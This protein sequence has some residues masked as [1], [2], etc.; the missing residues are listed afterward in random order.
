MK[1]FTTSRI[2]EIDALTIRHE[3]VASVDLMERAALACTIWLEERFS[4]DT[5]FI[6]LTGPGNNGGDGWAIGRLLA[7][8]GY[9]NIRLFSVSPFS[10]LSTDAAINHQRLLDQNLVPVTVIESADQFP[11]IRKNDIILDSLF[12]S[13]LSRPLNGL[14]AEL[15][16]HINLSGAGV[17]AVDLPS[18]LMGEDNSGN[19]PD[20]IVKAKHTL[21]FQF[22]KLSFFFSENDEFVGEWT[23]LDIGLHRE[24]IEKTGTP[25]YYLTRDD[26]SRM[27]RPRRKFSHKGTYGHALLIAGSYGMMG[28]AVLASKACLRAG[29]GL[30]TV[31]IPRK[32]YDILQSAVPE[33]IVSLDPSDERFSEPPVLASYSAVGAGPGIGTTPV[34]EHALENLLQNCSKPLV[35]DADALNLIAAHKEWLERIP[36][37]SILTPHPK[38]FERLAGKSATGYD[39]LMKQIEFARDRKVILV[40]KGANTSIAMPDGTCYFN[41]TGNPGMATGGSGD[42]LTGMILSL[43][44]QGYET[45]D[46]ARTG[47]YLHGLAG[48]L[49]ACSAGRNSLI[50]S[51]ITEH[52]GSAFMKTEILSNDEKD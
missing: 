18:G 50:A 23:I 22:P 46:A 26:I 30:V 6:I 38:E 4:R 3:P 12:G 5:S 44:A 45:Y 21:T 40:L 37:N 2:R 10:E 25:Y 14:A 52:I 24:S 7:G 42:V 51:D 13:G 48:D 29:A 34:V 11:V 9:S 31:H 49:A 41:S 28:A 39:R 36:A 47:V 8:K 1:V 16:K 43:L 20:T 15:V 27:I 35:I 17:I 19:T 33:A 32:G